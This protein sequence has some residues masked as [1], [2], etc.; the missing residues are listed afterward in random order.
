MILGV[1]RNELVQFVVIVWP[2]SVERL[3][4]HLVDVQA[5]FAAMTINTAGAEALSTDTKIAT[6]THAVDDSR[7]AASVFPI[8]NT[9]V[10]DNQKRL[11][12]LDG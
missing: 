5:I 11:S 6:A 10:V 1:P 2:T 12:R 4:I 9:H 7:A 3:S 8:A